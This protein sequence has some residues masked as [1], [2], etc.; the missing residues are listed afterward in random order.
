MKNE[1]LNYDDV[2]KGLECRYLNRPKKQCDKCQF[3][4]QVGMCFGCDLPALCG[5][6]ARFLYE[7]DRMKNCVNCIH[8]DVC[9][10]VAM[11]KSK[12]A[13][14][15]SPCDNWRMKDD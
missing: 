9:K 4:I 3:G 15:Y 2:I 1:N 13:N 8:Y 14:D 11:R 7:R 5:D 6:A 12:A 10:T